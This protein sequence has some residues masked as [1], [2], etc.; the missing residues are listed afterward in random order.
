MTTSTLNTTIDGRGAL[1]VASKFLLQERLSRFFKRNLVIDY[2]YWLQTGD[3][4]LT[5]L[6]QQ[7]NGLND[8]EILN[9]YHLLGIMGGLDTSI[10]NTTIYV[11]G[12][13]GNDDTGLG[14]LAAPFKSLWFMET[15]PRRINHKYR[16]VLLS[17]VSE[18]TT[19][20][21]LD[22]S[23]GD[24]G[25]FSILGRGAPTVIES[26]TVGAIGTLTGGGGSYCA[27]TGNFGP[28]A[29][30]SFLVGRNYAVPIHKV[31]G[32]N[33]LFQSM[34]FV[35]GGVGGGDALQVV[36]PAWTLTVKNIVATCQGGRRGKQSQVGIFN[37]NIDFPVATPPYFNGIE[38]LIHWEN[39]C[40]STLSFV[41][42]TE[43]WNGSGNQ[44]GNSFR[45]GGVNMNVHV[46]QNEISALAN[47]GILN[48]DGPDTTT[49]P[50]T[51]QI[52]GAKFGDIGASGI[53]EVTVLR[54]IEMMAMDFDN[55]IN[56]RNYAHI[57][58][59][60]AVAWI[61]RSANFKLEYSIVDGI[62]TV[63]LPLNRGG[64]EGY[65][66]IMDLISYTTLVSNNCLSL[67]GNCYVR[68]GVCGSD[69]TYST[70]SNAGI[71]CRGRNTVEAW[72]ND[73]GVTP[74]N[75]GMV[76]AT[77]QLIG[78]STTGGEVPDVWPA[79]DVVVNLDGYS[80]IYLQS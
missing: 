24:D 9:L 49:A 55:L 13:L 6:L 37:L 34:P 42:F 72:Y 40:E 1:T 78:F 5:Q 74:V 68:I 36:K 48:L 54:D 18:P 25:A 31:I 76:G 35:F 8:T 16:V 59:C 46:D 44:L 12:V 4:P 2:N 47:C 22:F 27:A 58:Y 30:S 3:F 38:A 26:N 53:A 20:L 63:S 29:Q 56:I 33:C 10:Q 77:A 52:C 61:S 32:A 75:T 7:L 39:R 50:Y 17:N 43:R 15:L 80:D 41:R 71:W 57:Q 28:Q 65:D 23:F 64:V 11:D 45:Y 14:T 51:P 19:T 21:K 62:P 73:P 66:S 79:V 69:L 70:I 60:N 67:F